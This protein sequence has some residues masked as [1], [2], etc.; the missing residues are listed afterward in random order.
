MTYNVGDPGHVKA[1]GDLVSSINVELARF[2]LTGALPI[3]EEGSE[4]H[5]DDHNAI[6]AKLDELA[7]HA[8]QTFSTPLPPVRQLGDGSHTEDHNNLALCASEVATWPA[9]N[10]ASGGLEQSVGNYN[11]TGQRWMVHTFTGNGTFTVTR[12]TQ[13]FRVLVVGGGGAG[14]TGVPNGSGGGGGGGGVYARDTYTLQ[15]RD[16]EMTIGASAYSVGDYYP[17]GPSGGDTTFDDIG[18]C[19]GGG[20]GGTGA[21]HGKKPAG[22][23]ATGRTGSLAN[24]GNGGAGSTDHAAPA[25]GSPRPGTTSDITGTSVEYGRAGNSTSSQGNYG[26][27]GATHAPSGSIAA[28]RSKAGV[29]IVAYRIS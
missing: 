7:T 14:G 29:V 22:G 11:G 6:R 2:G 28:H 15:V 1:H 21:W 5:L 12:A 8:G 13:P 18:V 4:G 24:G 10:A 20:G 19:G 3:K 25:V 9:W 23:G 27:G 17:S 16:Y 26:D